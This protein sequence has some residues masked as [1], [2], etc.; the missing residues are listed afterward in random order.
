MPESDLLKE[1]DS[2]FRREMEVKSKLDDKASAIITMAGAVTTIFMGFGIFLLRDVT[3]QSISILVSGS[4]FLLSEVIL[5]TCAIRFA[6]N[7]YKLREYM[8]PMVHTAFFRPEG[9]YNEEMVQRFVAVSE[10]DFQLHMIEQYLN[11]I[12]NNNRANGDKAV[13]VNTAQRLYLLALSMIPP[14]VLTIVIAKF[15]S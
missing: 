11:S 1:L 15:L 8:Y 10:K 3:T 2:Q 4:L 9:T 13:L 5:T 6:I 7:A 12:R 14:F